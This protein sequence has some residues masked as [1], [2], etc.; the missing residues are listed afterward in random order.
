MYAMRMP[1]SAAL[2]ALLLLTCMSGSAHARFM[3]FRPHG[4]TV[5]QMTDAPSVRAVNDVGPAVKNATEAALARAQA[6]LKRYANTLRVVSI[7]T[8][9]IVAFLGYFLLTPV[10]FGAG[11]VVG[12]GV[13]SVALRALLGDATPAAVWTGVVGTLAAGI[14][15]GLIAVKMLSVG[16]FAVGAS[17]GVVVASALKPSVLGHVYPPNADVGFVIGSIVLGLALGT[18]ALRFQ[19]QMVIFATAYG[20]AFAFFFG[21][22]YFAGHFPTAAELVRAEKGHFGNWLIMYTSLTAIIGT[23]GT[24]TQ[25]KLA[26]TRPLVQSH[27]SRRQGWGNGRW[28]RREED[29]SEERMRLPQNESGDDLKKTP[30]K[31]E[32]IEANDKMLDSANI[33]PVSLPKDEGS[34]EIVVS[35]DRTLRYYGKVNVRDTLDQ[36]D[37]MEGKI[38]Y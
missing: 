30:A 28:R 14:V 20:G 8:G 4:A 10:L 1:R 7:P 23:A 38:L 37:T 25:F 17:L 18:M 11:L 29:L 12:G 34:T 24:I 27:G 15:V 13:A 5:L 32:T 35:S 2:G 36:A 31:F 6:V 3:R 19:K 16:M 21:I 9:I 22:G 26:S 33:D